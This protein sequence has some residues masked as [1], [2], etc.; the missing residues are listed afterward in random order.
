MPMYEISVSQAVKFYGQLGE[1][2]RKAALKGVFSAALRAKRDVVSK[3]IAKYGPNKPVDRGIYRAGWQ[4]ERLPNG[5]AIY[6]SVPHAMFIE[7][8]VPASRVVISNKA[9][10]NMTEWVRRKLGGPDNA[11]SIAV[12]ILHS[13]KKRGIF[14]NGT[15]LRIFEAY[16]LNMLP[17]ILNQEISREISKAYRE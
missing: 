8:G 17:I 9:I 2:L 6:N 15:G 16:C 12:A 4:V 5:A 10:G 7:Y 11:R 13:L 1:N 3:E 14:N